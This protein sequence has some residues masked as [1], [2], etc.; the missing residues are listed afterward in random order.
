MSFSP[1]L[2]Q[3]ISSIV[4]KIS[5]KG[6]PGGWLRSVPA[7]ASCP[8]WEVRTE[9]AG[10]LVA[11][12]QVRPVGAET[13]RYCVESKRVYDRQSQQSLAFRSIIPGAILMINLRTAYTPRIT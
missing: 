11:I 9:I 7:D 12:R 2:R 10:S 4:P 3:R 8:M 1:F 6:N 5:M 13:R